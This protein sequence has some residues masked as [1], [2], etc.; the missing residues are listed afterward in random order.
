MPASRLRY[1][2][3]EALQRQFIEFVFRMREQVTARHVDAAGD[4]NLRVQARRIA[5]RSELR[6]DLGDRS[7]NGSCLGC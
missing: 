2:V 3:I 7:C 5:A 4:Q 1:R 6:G